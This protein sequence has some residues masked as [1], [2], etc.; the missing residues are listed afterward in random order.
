MNYFLCNLNLCINHRIVNGKTMTIICNNM[1]KNVKK[2][3]WKIFQ[4]IIY[5]WKGKKCSR[6]E[7]QNIELGK[8]LDFLRNLKLYAVYIW[9]SPNST[10][11]W[12]LTRK[13]GLRYRMNLWGTFMEIVKGHNKNFE[14]VKVRGIGYSRN[15]MPI[16]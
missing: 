11:S 9:F 7:E 2:K 13:C 6:E 4:D 16:V 10:I 5:T 3:T 12:M 8:L 14:I 15:L 1:V